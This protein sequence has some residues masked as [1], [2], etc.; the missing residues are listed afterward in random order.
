[1]KLSGRDAARYFDKP[2]TGGA[3]ALL[4]GADAMRVAHRRKA[5]IL[6]LI[7]PKGAEEMRLT[8][9]SGADLRR[10][11]AALNDA[12]KA[13]GF[14]PGARAVLVDEAGDGNAEAI[15]ATLADWR[16]GDAA[17][18]VT[19]GTLTPRSALRKAFETAKNAFAIGIYADA[20]RRDEIEAAL[21]RAGLERIEPGA[22]ADLEALAA[23]LDPGDFDQVLEKIAL[24]MR[25]VADPLSS[26]DVAACAPP[27]PEA[28]LDALIDLVAS[29]RAD[30]LARAFARLGGRS[31]A[32]T[33][34]TIAAARHFRLLYAASL[35]PA[36][37]DAALSRARPPVFGP[38]RARMAAQARA[39]GPARLER[40][41]DQI[42]EAELRL[43]SG[44]P[45]PGLALVE[46]LFV[47]IARMAQG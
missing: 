16:P 19:A 17:M 15:R 1:M 42:L 32:S 40:V 27:P 44:R 31:G 10:D 29:G 6:A 46:R 18:V 38:R 47:R 2:D 23:G 43:R 21:T 24:Y 8:R 34:L 13:V 5:L 3:G 22:M 41:L 7:G 30:A 4:Y 14:F 26:A 25:G 37:P 36:G 9:L 33:S 11:P 35:D 39:F 12:V 45:T 20:M 28:E